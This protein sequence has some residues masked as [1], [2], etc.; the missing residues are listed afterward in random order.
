MKLRQLP[1]SLALA[2]ARGLSMRLGLTLGLLST[3]TGQA[4]TTLHY[5]TGGSSVSGN[6]SS[7]ANWLGGAAPSGGDQRLIFMAGA[8]RKVNTNDLPAGTSF[9]S[10]WVVD[11]GYNIYGN[12]VRIHYLRG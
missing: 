7:G 9:E 3:V 12:P 2:G 10:I 6:W 1:D 8:A 4:S 5:W 11:D